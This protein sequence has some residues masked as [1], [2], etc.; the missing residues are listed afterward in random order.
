MPLKLFEFWNLENVCLL[1]IKALL[2]SA[3]VRRFKKDR[4]HQH[5][6][7]WDLIICNFEESN[8]W[9][10]ILLNKWIS[11]L[12]KYVLSKYILYNFRIYFIS[13]PGNQFLGRTTTWVF[14]Q[15]I[16]V[17]RYIPTTFPFWWPQFCDYKNHI[18]LLI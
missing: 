6:K 12:L 7:S 2:Y 11:I 1:L 10:R 5:W 4:K 3:K 17:Y 18:L 16:K 9:K 14:P 8:A 13:F 15:K